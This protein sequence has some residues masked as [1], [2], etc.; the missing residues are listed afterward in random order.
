ML[1]ERTSQPNAPTDSSAGGLVG[2]IKSALGE[3]FGT[4][5][6]RGRGMSAAEIAL[7]SAIQAAARSAGTKIGQAISRGILGGR[8]K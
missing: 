5:G 4:S 2:S 1:A 8:S 7:R 3:L 6:R